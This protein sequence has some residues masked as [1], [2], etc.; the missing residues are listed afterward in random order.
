MH[1]EAISSGLVLCYWRVCLTDKL[2]KYRK[3]EELFL[4]FFL[5]PVQISHQEVGIQVAVM[6]V[7][8]HQ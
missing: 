5:T 2:T 1:L 8:Y 3:S 4:I 7:F 6:I